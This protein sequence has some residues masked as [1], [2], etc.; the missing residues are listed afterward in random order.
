[1][2]CI[3]AYV[4]IL[5]IYGRFGVFFMISARHP[6]NSFISPHFT[7]LNLLPDLLHPSPWL[8]DLLTL[9]TLTSEMDPPTVH[10]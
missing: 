7:Y 5:T 2:S 1:M 8:Q 10:L 4:Q 9:C 6:V 3:K